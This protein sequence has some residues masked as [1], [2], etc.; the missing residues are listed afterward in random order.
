MYKGGTLRQPAQN[1]LVLLVQHG[2]AEI[3]KASREMVHHHIRGIHDHFLQTIVSRKKRE[4]KDRKRER[5]KRESVCVRE[6]ESEEREEQ[7]G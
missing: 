1:V 4:K 3:A 2:H 7:K 5:E 6:S